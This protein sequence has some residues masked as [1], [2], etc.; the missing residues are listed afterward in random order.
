MRLFFFLLESYIEKNI[1]NEIIIAISRV[2]FNALFFYKNIF[3]RDIE[4]KIGEVL[5]TF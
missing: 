4:A 3:Y 2:N 5:R 1:I